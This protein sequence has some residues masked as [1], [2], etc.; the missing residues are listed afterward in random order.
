M[1]KNKK[2]EKVSKKKEELAIG[3]DLTIESF[4]KPEEPYVVATYRLNPKCIDAPAYVRG[5][6]KK[7]PPYDPFLAY[8]EWKMDR[9]WYKRLFLP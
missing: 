6:P 2:K 8:L 5:I 7:L 3:R 9:P 4:R 1:S